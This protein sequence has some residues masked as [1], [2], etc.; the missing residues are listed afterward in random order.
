MEYV[1]II[2]ESAGLAWKG[3]PLSRVCSNGQLVQ[4]LLLFPRCKTELCGQLNQSISSNCREQI[5]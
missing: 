1:E 5:L 2:V 4:V 3:T